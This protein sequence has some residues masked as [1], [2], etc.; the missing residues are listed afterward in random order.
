MGV[1]QII[2]IARTIQIG[3]HD[4]HVLGAVLAVV[5]LTQLDTSDFCQSIR[6]IGLFQWASEQ[7]LFFDRLWAVSWINAA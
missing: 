3:W 6:L 5:V 4:A 2:V 1:V 7:I